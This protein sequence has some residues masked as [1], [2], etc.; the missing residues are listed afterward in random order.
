MEIKLKAKGLSSY[1]AAGKR[2]IAGQ[3]YDI[4][5]PDVI[6]AVVDNAWFDLD[7]SQAYAIIH[8]AEELN[9]DR[10]PV[11]NVVVESTEEEPEM[12]GEA[13]EFHSPVQDDAIET[14]DPA[15]DTSMDADDVF[16]N[17]GVIVESADVA[18]ASARNE[19][20]KY[21][22]PVENCE[23][24][25]ENGFARH[26][27]VAAHVNKVHVVKDEPVSEAFPGMASME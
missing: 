22:C 9:L 17:E 2:F 3:D 25:G 18:A 23:K 19:F 5:D 21:D 1:Y 12:S 6:R 11:E 13:V 10:V 20:D 4:N 7:R 24:I 14:Y 16:V 8:G 27:N 26:G 15:Y